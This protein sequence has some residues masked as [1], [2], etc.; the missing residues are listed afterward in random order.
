MNEQQALGLVK[1]F[2]GELFEKTDQS[3]AQALWW[4]Q[5]DKLIT[6]EAANSILREY[7]KKVEEYRA[8]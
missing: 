3:L 2:I 1:N 6:Q 5:T 4:A 7:R 8:N